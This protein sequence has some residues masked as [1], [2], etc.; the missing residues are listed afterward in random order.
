MSLMLKPIGVSK[1]DLL[2]GLSVIGVDMLRPI[3]VSKYLFETF[4]MNFPS[5][6]KLPMLALLN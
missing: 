1:I 2:E 4:M 5:D 3:D 6:M